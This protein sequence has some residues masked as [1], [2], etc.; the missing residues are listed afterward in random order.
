M[1]ILLMLALMAAA[2]WSMAAEPDYADVYKLPAWIERVAPMCP[3]KSATEE[4]YVRVIRTDF[5]G[6]HQLF[7]QWVKKADVGTENA[8]EILSTRA[9]EE[10][11][12]TYSVRVEMPRAHLNPTSCELQAEAEALNI[13]QRYRMNIVLREPGNYLLQ[14]TRLL[15]GGGQ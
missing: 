14:V 3:W 13:K 8:A 10:L 15:D 7:L 11:E 6:R 4:G 2:P 5:H 9:V 12:T 1:R